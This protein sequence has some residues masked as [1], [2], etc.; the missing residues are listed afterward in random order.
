MHLNQLY[1]LIKTY[2]SNRIVLAHWG[3]GLFF[4]ALMKKE[5]KAVLTNVWF[6]TAAS[7]YLYV[8]DIYRV[9]GEI[10]GYEKILFGS[11]YPL[12]SPGRYM[13]EM[14]SAGISSEAFAAMVGEN[15]RDLL[16]L[17]L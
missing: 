10:I 12:L 17:S 5:V 13:R 2:P 15:A 11:D 3:G 16:G 9:A 4:Y 7:P 6:D 1:D 14:E 8:P